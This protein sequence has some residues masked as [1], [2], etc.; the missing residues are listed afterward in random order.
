M[1]ISMPKLGD[2]DKPLT[3]K[4]LSNPTHAVTKHILYLYTMESFIYGDL[5]WACRDKDQSKLE[6]YGAYAAAL[7]YI[8]YNANKNKPIDTLSVECNKLYTNL[9]RGV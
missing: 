7:S 3:P 1:L 5:N 2:I 8:I 4:V 9:Y 6:Y